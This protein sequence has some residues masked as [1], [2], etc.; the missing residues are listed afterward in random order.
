MRSILFFSFNIYYIQVNN[1][2]YFITGSLIYSTPQRHAS[3]IN[4]TSKLSLEFLSYGTLLKCEE[5]IG[6]LGAGC[7]CVLDK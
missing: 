5:P 3:K 6:R 1:I 2:N 4:E 7:G